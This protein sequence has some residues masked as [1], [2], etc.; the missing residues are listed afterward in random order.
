MTFDFECIFMEKLTRDIEKILILCVF[1]HHTHFR[2][3]K[4]WGSLLRLRDNSI[5]APPGVLYQKHYFYHYNKQGTD[6]NIINSNDVLFI[7]MFL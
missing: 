2:K 1:V 4:L 6:S 7:N 3:R 5:N